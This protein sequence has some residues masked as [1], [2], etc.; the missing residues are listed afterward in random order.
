MFQGWLSP[1]ALDRLPSIA[2]TLFVSIAILRDDGGHALGGHQRQAKASWRA[3]IENVHRIAVKFQSLG[4]C[5]DRLCQRVEGEF[6]VALRRNLSEAEARQIWSD[7]PI[8]VG[9]ARNQFSVL[10]R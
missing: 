4:K 2:Q 8:A 10:K 5:E 9:E 3:V 6:I 7:H 1:V